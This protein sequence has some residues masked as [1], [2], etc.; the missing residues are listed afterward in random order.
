MSDNLTLE[1]ALLVVP[2]DLS[3]TL[4]ASTVQTMSFIAFSLFFSK[5]LEISRIVFV[6]LQ[7]GMEILGFK[8]ILQ[9]Y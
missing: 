2:M 3:S 6:F 9:N 4:S 7:C 8:I 1:F 5:D